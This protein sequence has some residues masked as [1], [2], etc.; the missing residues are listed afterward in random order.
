MKSSLSVLGGI[1]MQ[2]IR[3]HQ[4]NFKSVYV[5]SDFGNRNY[6]HGKRCLQGKVAQEL[7][8]RSPKYMAGSVSI[9]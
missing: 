9:A 5:T 7:K 3:I 1:Q 8:Y 6:N 2:T 4:K